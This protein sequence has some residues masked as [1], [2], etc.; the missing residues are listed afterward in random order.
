MNKVFIIAEAG[1]NHNGKKNLAYKLVDIAVKAGADAIKFQTFTTENMVTKKVS[2][3]E[4][5][6]ENSLLN[7]TQFEMLK[8]LELSNQTFR[9]LK[10]YCNK[11]K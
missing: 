7:Q 10:N 9:E 5:Q 4:Y 2:K 11:K 8:K 1:V 3:A 6:K